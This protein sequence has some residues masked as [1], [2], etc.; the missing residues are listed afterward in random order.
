MLPAISG[1]ET[2]ELPQPGQVGRP[3]RLELAQ[4]RPVTGP[5]PVAQPGRQACDIVTDTS[6][7]PPNADCGALI[8]GLCWPERG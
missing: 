4:Y 2:S 6:D 5:N 1:A 7:L 8:L 3:L